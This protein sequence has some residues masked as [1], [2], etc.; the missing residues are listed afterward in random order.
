[1][2]FSLLF[3]TVL[4]LHGTVTAQQHYLCYYTAE[5]VAIDGLAREAAW[6]NAPWTT[7]FIDIEGDGL[8]KP[9]LR[10]RMKMLWDSTY[11]YI[12]AQLEEP[13]VWGT[14]TQHDAVIYHDNDFEAFIDPDGDGLN[15][16]ELEINALGTE[17]DLFLPKPYRVGGKPLLNWDVQGL[18]KAV[19]VDGTV[20]N[21]EDRDKGWSVELAI[22][23]KSV[24][25]WGD[26]PV[27]PG[28]T[29]RINFSR[30]EW[31]LD[32]R[33]GKYAPVTDV[34]GVRLPEHNW[35]WSPQG[36]INMHM[37]EMWGYLQFSA[38]TGGRDTVA[39]VAPEDVAARGYLWKVYYLEQ[40]FRKANGRYAV[41]M[42]ELGGFATISGKV[43]MSG[44]STTAVDDKGNV[45][46][47]H[48][49]ATTVQFTAGIGSLS[50][51]QDGKIGVTRPA[52]P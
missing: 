46:M 48:L 1:M 36:A 23:L 2:R 13:N 30:V 8:P 47:I 40:A 34:K 37:P 4:A 43:D 6:Q 16:F 10:T 24:L 14:L 12:Y 42:K 5:P 20:N 32:V 51:D 28:D 38:H 41:S 19:H 45:H 3:L 50:I 26:R 35:V 44:E 22:P 21:A 52:G 9:P 15:Y 18:K 39:F 29:W 49:A 25:F 7:D 33:N 17:M 27:K 31:D 11:L